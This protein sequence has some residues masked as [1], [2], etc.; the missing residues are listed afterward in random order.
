MYTASKEVS[1][2]PSVY[3]QFSTIDELDFRV[4]FISGGMKT[5]SE[6]TPAG[7]HNLGKLLNLFN[8]G[9]QY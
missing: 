1:F 5:I 7:K 8:N 9:N 3:V 2:T 6:K 4:T